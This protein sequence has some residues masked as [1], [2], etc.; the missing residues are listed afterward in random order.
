MSNNDDEKHIDN[1]QPIRFEIEI[2]RL[3]IR[4][5]KDITSG[6]NYG[7]LVA[8]DKSGQEHTFGYVGADG[9]DYQIYV[10][11]PKSGK[12]GWKMARDEEG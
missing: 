9:N 4:I 1:T 10:A 12:V 5:A 6:E 8:I 2:E 3:V 11:T 7:H